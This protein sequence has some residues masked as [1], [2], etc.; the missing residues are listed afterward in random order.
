M[1]E[2]I[3]VEDE[4]EAR[5][6]NAGNAPTCCQVGTFS[7]SPVS[8]SESCVR[9]VPRRRVTATTGPLMRSVALQSILSND[10]ASLLGRSRPPRS[11]PFSG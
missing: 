7:A 1:L 8:L 5:S 11:R 2:L 4:R 10:G 9:A 6:Q 3:W